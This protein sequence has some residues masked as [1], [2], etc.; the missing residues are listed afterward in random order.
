MT[1]PTPPARRSHA[2]RSAATRRHLIDTAIDVMQRRSLEDVSIHEI[3]RAAGMT[4][5]AVQHHFESKAVLM[6]HILGELLQVHADAGQLWPAASLDVHERAMQFVHN[7]WQLIYA[8]PRFIVAWN[9][10][11]GSRSQPEIL[12][13]VAALRAQ[14]GGQ[15]EAGFFETFP[16]LAALPERQA[17]LGLVLS[18]LRGLGMLQLFPGGPQTPASEQ[19]SGQLAC[20][21]NLIAVRCEA[22]HCEAARTAKAVP[23]PCLPHQH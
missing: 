10:Y 19:A 6:M 5:G 3:A 18:A 21:A 4:S 2:Q 16:E 7:A 17:F 12:E 11:L 14:V 20:L 15:M 23:A 22:A 1:H 9:I 8:Q 13:H